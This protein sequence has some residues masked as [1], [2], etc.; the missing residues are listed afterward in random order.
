MT[1]KVTGRTVRATLAG[2]SL[3][4]VAACSTSGPFDG[5]LRGYGQGGFSTSDAVRSATAA[6]PVPD[7]RGVISYPGYQVAVARQGDTPTSVAARV[8]LDAQELA[9]YNA[10]Q[11]NA[12][13]RAGEVLALPRRVS[14]TGVAGAPGSVDVAAVAGGAISRATTTTPATGPA[15]GPTTGGISATPIATPAPAPTGAGSPG[16]E[17]IRHKVQRGETAYSI[18]RLYNVNVKALADWNGLGKDLAVREGQTLL[19]PVGAK[20]GVVLTDNDS[21]PGEGS[22]TPTPPSASDPL[23]END[24]EP[25]AKPVE[26]PPAPDLGATTSAKLAMPV[27]GSIIRGYEKKKN[28]GIDIA[29]SAGTAVGAAADGT[30]AAITKDTQGVPILVIRHSGNLLTVYA[31]IDAI[32]VNKGDKVT[33]GQKVA[34]VRKSDPAFLHFEVRQGFDSVDPMP[35]LQ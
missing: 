20:G 29:A 21:A 7:Q 2:V 13:L 33:R 5:D 16:E 31:N 24:T 30:V 15:S 1:G 12:V 22:Q 23:P 28:D 3:L 35:F 6:R 4:A 14:E 11:P 8:G 27:Q 25:A 26:P 19:I 10:L 17:P 18:A 32:A 9:A 34:T